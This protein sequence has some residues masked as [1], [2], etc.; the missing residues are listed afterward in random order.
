LKAN[1]LL[2]QGF[3][4]DDGTQ[5]NARQMFSRQSYVGFSGNWGEVKLGRM[6]TAFDDISG[7]A[8]AAFDSALSP[9]NKVWLS[10]GYHGNPNNSVYFASPNIM[11]FTYAASYSFG[12]NKSATADA[13]VFV[14]FNVKYESGPLYAGV[15]YQVENKD[16]TFATV[17]FTRLNGSYDLG[18]AKVLVGYGSKV[19][20]DSRTNEWE[21]GADYPVSPALTLSG[22]IAR[23][24][25][26]LAAGD[27]TRK[28]YGLAASYSL[29][30]RTSVYTGYQSSTKTVAGTD[31]DATLLAIGMRHA[32]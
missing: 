22:G 1:F 2:E 18:V 10:T 17:K 25:D 16:S 5:G 9:Q 13:G 11:G 27:A 19:V 28:G 15:A 20:N 24:S 4:L 32:F 14:S 26:N 21:L 30:K 31:T 8:N 23:S 12:E 6:Y 7:A 3:N 29:S